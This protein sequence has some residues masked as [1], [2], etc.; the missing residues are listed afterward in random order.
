MWL[1]EI[2]GILE[3]ELNE[4][5]HVEVIDGDSEDP[6][7]YVDGYFIGSGVPGEEGYLIEILKK[8]RRVLRGSRDDV[9]I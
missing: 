5:I 7:F 3:K 4:S 8:T 2:K 9:S 1:L 6:E